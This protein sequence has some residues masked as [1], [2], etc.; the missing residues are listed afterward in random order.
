MATV[1]QKCDAQFR[2]PPDAATVRQKFV[3]KCRPFRRNSASAT[4]ERQPF[5]KKCELHPHQRADKLL[6]YRNHKPLARKSAESVNR[7]AEMRSPDQ[8][9]DAIVQ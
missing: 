4:Q 5:A 1:R 8:Q 3:A 9:T 2:G 7:P 6:A